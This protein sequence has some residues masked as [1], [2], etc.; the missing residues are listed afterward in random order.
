MKNLTLCIFICLLTACGASDNS[1][2]AQLPTELQDLKG[3]WLKACEVDLDDNSSSKG[4]ETYSEKG[5]NFSATTYIDSDCSVESISM[6]FTAS[7]NY[8]GEK[9]INSGQSVKKIGA[10]INTSNVLILLHDE[11]LI[12]KY[13]EKNVCNRIDW[14]SGKYINI[15][16]CYD[17]SDIVTNLKEPLKSIYLIDGNQA[18]WGNG[19]SI[20]DE[21]GFATEL[22]SIPNT[23][24]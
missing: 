24:I 15:S 12:A 17:L 13:N 21:N 2:S 5:A 23:K 7:I 20:E 9:I 22:E 4:I 16:A 11:N 18:Y 1:K 6:K 3:S 10:I 14:D 8:L 19:E